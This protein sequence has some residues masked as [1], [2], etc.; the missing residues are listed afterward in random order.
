[1]DWRKEKLR[2]ALKLNK[3]RLIFLF[4]AGLILFILAA[5]G[6]RKENGEDF[7]APDD[8]ADSVPAALVTAAQSDTYEKILEERVRAILS[9]VEGVGKVDVMVM[10]KSSEER[11]FRVDRDSSTTWNEGAEGGENSRLTTQ[12]EIA[13]STVLEGNGTSPIVEKELMPEISGIVISADGGGSAVVRAEI[14]GA[15]EAL[16][17]LPS[18]KIKVLKRIKEGA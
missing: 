12:Q 15:M 4:C 7:T 10:L 16:F 9:G 6:G 18:H 1:M 5:P 14:S 13:E 8:G 3:E 2:S 11:I 17:G